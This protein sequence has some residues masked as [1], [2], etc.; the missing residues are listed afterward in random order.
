MDLTSFKKYP[1]QISS[2]F[3][4][5][6]LASALAIFS[7][8][9]FICSNVVMPNHHDHNPLSFWL[10]F[11]PIGAMVMALTTKLVQESKK[12]V[13]KIPQIVAGLTWLAISIALTLIYPDDKDHYKSVY[14]FGTI[15]FIYITIFIIKSPNIKN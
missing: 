12:S 1:N 5:F 14:L 11:Y 6:P 15:Y 2:A 7:T 3:K 4:R 8:I 13:S 9:S 10:A